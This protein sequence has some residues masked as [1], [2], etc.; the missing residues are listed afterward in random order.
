MLPEGGRLETGGGGQGTGDGRRRP[1]RRQ[2]AQNCQ[3]SGGRPGHIITRV[4]CLLKSIVNLLIVTL[5]SLRFLIALRAASCRDP[6]DIKLSVTDRPVF[7]ILLRQT[8]LVGWRVGG[9]QACGERA[10]VDTGL[11]AIW[12]SGAANKIHRQRPGHTLR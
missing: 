6:G 5:K 11:Y 4:Q 7:A 9:S 8:V 3:T 12:L 1:R 10:V 2:A